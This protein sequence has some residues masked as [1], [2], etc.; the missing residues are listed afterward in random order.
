MIVI[1]DPEGDPEIVATA[2]WAGDIKGRPIETL[3]QAVIDR[4]IATQTPMV[5]TGH[6]RA[7]RCFASVVDLITRGLTSGDRGDRVSFLG[8]P[9]KADDRVIGTLSIDRVWDARRRS[10]STRTCGS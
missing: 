10:A 6:R 7:S 2:G 9:I 3:P 4:L 5:V 1:V 8:V